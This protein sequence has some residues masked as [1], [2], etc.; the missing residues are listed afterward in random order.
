MPDEVLEGGRIEEGRQ[1]VE[2]TP[3]VADSRRSIVQKIL[4]F[5]QETT[6]RDP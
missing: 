3:T 2:A 1:G 6:F 5:A 4:L